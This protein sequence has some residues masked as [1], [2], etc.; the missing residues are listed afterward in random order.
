M[1]AGH[2]LKGSYVE[3]QLSEGRHVTAADE[4]LSERQVS[5]WVTKVG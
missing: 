5:P 4:A 3:D 2:P 1:A